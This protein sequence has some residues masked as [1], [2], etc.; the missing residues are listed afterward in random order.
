[1]MPDDQ[2]QPAA[3]TPLP[4]GASFTGETSPQQLS[5]QQ[6]ASVSSGTRTLSQQDIL[7]QDI[8]Q[9]VLNTL[10]LPLL[11]LDV[12][13]SVRFASRAFHHLFQVMPE[14]TLGKAVSILGS[15]QWAG[16]D[17]NCLL[18]QVLS[19]HTPFK[20]FEVTSVLPALGLRTMLLSALELDPVSP[21]LDGSRPTETRPNEIDPT[22]T[23]ASLMLLLVFEDITK[24]EAEEARLRTQRR[25][26]RALRARGRSERAQPIE[27]ADHAIRIAD[28]LQRALLQPIPENAFPD[29]A[30]TAAHRGAVDGSLGGDFFDAFLLPSGS[31]ALV[32][33]DVEGH[34]LEA[35]MRIGE[36]KYS[37]W[38][39][40]QES[41]DAAFTLSRLNDMVNTSHHLDAQAERLCTVVSL[42]VISPY[43]WEATFTRAGAEPP[44][45]LTADGTWKAV[46][47]AG[48]MLGA[49]EE[50][51]YAT[52]T[53]HLRKGETLLMFTDG[54]TEARVPRG[55]S[56][57]GKEGVAKQAHEALHVNG[58]L[59][60]EPLRGAGQ[61]VLGTALAHAHG[62]LAD[63]AC[64]VLT[65]QR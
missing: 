11:L 39:F 27:E 46:E 12:G 16:S 31:V 52:E 19:V 47:A 41:M 62:S 20:D 4:K 35:A 26:G 17:L 65:R 32:V 40:L 43:T 61:A 56:F 48:I 37:L 7:L 64:L 60:E 63:D 51:V 8:S 53:R 34:G 21:I 33:G 42:V 55:H 13:L 59:T 24:R 36:I 5:D 50:A 2:Q 49:R 58:L 15:G 29:L 22:F 14:Q 57:F 25:A 3:A 45:I 6:V 28:G 23:Q 10:S 1:M 30:V 54:L 44:L 38:A 9:Q 18:E